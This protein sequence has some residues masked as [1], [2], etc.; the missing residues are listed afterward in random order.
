MKGK[1]LIVD[2]YGSNIEVK[3][4][5]TIIDTKKEITKHSGSRL[6][7]DEFVMLQ[8]TKF[9]CKVT[10][11]IEPIAGLSIGEII[12]VS[13]DKIVEVKS[14]WDFLNKQSWLKR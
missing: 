2:F 7:D 4:L 12:K 8:Q 3:C 1:K 6:K 9:L 14:F 13:P 11:I 10:K 5:E